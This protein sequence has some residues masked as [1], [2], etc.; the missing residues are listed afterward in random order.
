[1]LTWDKPNERYY[2]HGLDRGVLYIPGLAPIPWNGLTGF[3]E[4]SNGATSMHYRDGVVYLADADASDFSGKMTSIY[5]PNEFG[6]CLGIPEVTDG[7]HA[8]NQKPKRFG[9]SYR[10][11]IGNGG[12]SDMF[13]YQ[14]HLVYNCMAAVSPRS[15]KTLG[16]E[17]SP[18]EFGFDIV[19][20]PKKLAGYRPTAHYVIDTRTMSKSK[21]AQLETLIYGDGVTPSTLP[22]PGALFD[23]MNYGTGIVVRVHTNGTYTV[24]GSSANVYEIDSNSF[25]MKNING[26]ANPDGTY[27][28]SDGGTTDV[29]IEP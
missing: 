21:V 17:S 6:K 14:I 26:V 28:I 4:G 13:G 24:E 8:D 11:L 12:A 9:L 29:I 3:E 7:F 22:E 1:M 2:E 10:S 19:C 25:Q 16:G 15:R 23:L 20:T 18:V 27:L 5:F